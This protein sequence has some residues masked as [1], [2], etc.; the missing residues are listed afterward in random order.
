MIKVCWISN[1]PSPYKV[2]LMNLLSKDL[3]L[4]ILFET[5]TVSDREKDW[6]SY[7]F[8]GYEVSYLNENYKEKIKKCSE[9]CDILINSDYSNKMCI[10]ATH[11]F[12]KKKKPVVLLAD[13]GLV[14][15]RG[16]FDHVISLVM[17]QCDY[18]MSSGKQV[19][20]YFNYYNIK[21]DKIFNY[22][23]SSLT[24]EDLANNKA[25]ANKKEELKKELNIKEKHVLFSV[26]Q[27]ITRKG[28][29][30]LV[31]AMKDVS[32]DVALIIAGGNVEDNVKK[33][34]D[35]NNLNN[36]YFI[37]FKNK[38]ELAKYYASSDIFVLNTRYD[39]WGLVINEAMSFGL[40]IISTN[41]CVA[42]VEFNNLFNNALINEVEDVNSLSSNINKLINDET[43]RLKLSNSSIEGIKEYTIDNTKE[44]FV[45]IINKIMEDYK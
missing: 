44:D 3:S 22:R 25:L 8:N 39:I 7:D 11:L 1:I 21:D 38:E 20:K 16:L 43:L 9:E 13:G 33:I 26:G 35:D 30:I 29:D 2:S 45:S 40:P 37:G 36:I 27:Q 34:I 17:K 41:K 31:S 15:K 24:L 4:S 42:A 18:F 6:F 28:Y 32:K 5:K 23:F 14:I 19:N 12:K 10:Y